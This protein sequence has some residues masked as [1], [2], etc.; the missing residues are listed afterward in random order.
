MDHSREGRSKAKQ[1]KNGGSVFAVLSNGLEL[2][3]SQ[4]GG[5][6]PDTLTVT[7]LHLFSLAAQYSW[8]LYP[9]M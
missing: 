5:S 3:T 7:V 4:S 1:S 6:E 8:Y 2:E 9:L